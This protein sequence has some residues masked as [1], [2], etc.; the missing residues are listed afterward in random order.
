MPF[1]LA[2]MPNHACQL[3]MQAGPYLTPDFVKNVFYGFISN[4]EKDSK[5]KIDI[6]LSSTLEGYMKT[7]LQGNADIFIFGEHSIS[8]FSKRN[9]IPIIKTQ[10]ILKSL[11]VVNPKR[12][13]VSKG[14]S[15]LK[16]KTVIVPS[17][18]S[19]T[20]M[21]FRD[22]IEN[23]NLTNKVN[24]KV[25]EN[26]TLN[27]L[28]FIKGEIDAL[29]VL[30]FVYKNLP[31]YVHSKFKI[32][33]QSE[34]NSVIMFGKSSLPASVSNSMKKNIH[35]FTSGNWEVF[36]HHRVNKYSKAFEELIIKLEQ[37]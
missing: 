22:Y 36:N 18:Y 21:H 8:A 27:T 7:I 25:Q 1:L 3:T 19:L 16:G 17:P 15:M 9:F 13:D 12:I 20:N 29:V 24:L 28:D 5:C 23:I 34:L 35:T 6:R 37:Q 26:Y 30:N 33:N 11:V 4:V 14:K 32:I 10:G 31:D 2:S